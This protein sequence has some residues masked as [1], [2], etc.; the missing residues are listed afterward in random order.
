VVVVIARRLQHGHVFRFRQKIV[1]VP[2]SL[3][4]SLAVSLAA[5]AG[6][7]AVLFGGFEEWS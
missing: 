3:W 5:F 6:A 2:R 1:Q 4:F 7:V